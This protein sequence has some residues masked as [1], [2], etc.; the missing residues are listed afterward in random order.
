MIDILTDRAR[1]GTPRQENCPNLLRILDTIL[2]FHF[3]HGKA[4]EVHA[5]VR[6]AI[7]APLHLVYDIMKRLTPDMRLIRDTVR[8]FP[9][10]IW[11]FAK[12]EIFPPGEVSWSP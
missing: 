6:L 2:Q 9:W 4:L 7:A 10:R 8:I 12:S 1:L 3:Q 5:V 11:L